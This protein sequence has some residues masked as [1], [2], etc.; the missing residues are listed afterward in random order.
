MKA[1]LIER[2]GGPEVLKTAEVAEPL[3]AAGE[4]LIEVE[5]A[6][7]NPVDWKIREGA[8]ASHIPH[9]FPLIPGWDAAGR[10]GAIGPGARGFSPGD[11]VFVYC[12]KPVVKMG[13]Y[14]ER[15]AVAA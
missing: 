9:E 1:I 5:Y 3:P 4:I 6:G 13:A 7:V 12:R 14:A 11:R 2:S 15:L 10:V 8:L